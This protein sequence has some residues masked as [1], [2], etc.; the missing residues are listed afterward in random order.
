LV[1][2][3]G[4]TAGTLLPT[5]DKTGSIAMAQAPGKVALVRA[6]TALACAGSDCSAD[7]LASIV[8]AIGYGSVNFNEGSAAAP[9]LTVSTAALRGAAGCT[10]NNQ[11]GS[12]FVAGAPNPR[13]TASAF[14]PCS[15]VNVPPQVSATSPVNGAAE[16][17]L[18]ADLSIGFSENVVPSGTWF[19]LGCSASG[20]VSA[21]VSGGP[22]TYTLNPTVDL[23]LGETCTVT[24]SAAAIVDSDGAP[25]ASDFVLSFTTSK[26]CAC[27]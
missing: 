5:P 13:N 2:E 19:S 12:D 25:M 8:D 20:S 21:V 6:T 11:N 26:T 16:V 14:T 1:Q 9:A 18:N 10:D 23:Q 24:I 4:G 7:K 22:Q 3:S 27:S 17:P 15:T